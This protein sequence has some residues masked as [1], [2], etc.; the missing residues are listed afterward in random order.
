[1]IQQIIP[2]LQSTF[3]AMDA[4]RKKASFDKLRIEAYSEKGK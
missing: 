4:H 2:A 3:Q 1:M